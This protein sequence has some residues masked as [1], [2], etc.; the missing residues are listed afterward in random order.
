MLPMGSL[1][2]QL[3]F[4]FVRPVHIIYIQDSQLPFP[5]QRISPSA[6]TR[7]VVPQWGIWTEDV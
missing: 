2:Y 4:P 5:D 7:R 1:I 3:R 6:E